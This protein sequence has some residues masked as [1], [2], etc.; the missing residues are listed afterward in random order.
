MQTRIG[1]K[2]VSDIQLAGDEL[3]KDIS[4]RLPAPQF[5]RS[6]LFVFS[7]LCLS[8]TALA[9]APVISGVGNV[10]NY[11]ENAAAVTIDSS[12]TITDSDSA[13][14]NQATVSL[15]TNFSSSEDALV[16]STVNGI[17]G[18]YDSGTGV[19]TLSGTAT[20]AN[21]EGALET[22]KYQNSSDDPSTATRTLSFVVRDTDNNESAADTTTLT[23]TA[24]NDA[25]VVSGVNNVAAFIEGL[26]PVVIDSTITITDTDN[27]NMSTGTV[28]ISG[29]N[30]SADSLVYSTLHGITGSFTNYG[31]HS[32][33]SLSGT[34]TKAQYEEA[35]E[36][37]QFSNSS[38][39]PSTATRTILFAV[40]D[41]FTSSNNPT[42]TLTVTDSAP[43]SISD[44]GNVASYTENGSAV[45][46]DS[47]VTIADT[48]SANLN[49][50]AVSLTTN[51]ASSEDSLVYSTVNGITGSYNSGTGV[52]TLS[53]TAT[54]AEYE[55]ALES[56]QYQ[57]TS[58]NPSTSTRTLSFVVRDTTNLNSTAD[59]T[60]LTVTAVND[61]PVISDVDN[62]P[63]FTENDAATVIDSTITITDADNG[64]MNQAT[65]S[66]TAN[67]SSS[68]DSLVY[69]TVNGITG[70]YN[71]GTGVL[72]LSGAT[73]KANYEGALETV[74]YQNSS[75][76]PSTSTRTISFVVRDSNNGSSSADT[77]TVTVAAVADAPVISGVNNVVSYT[78]NDVAT[79]IDSTIT[80]SDADH[81]NLNQA[82][83]SIT[84]N[85]SSSQDSLVYSTI[86]GIAGS[87]SSGTG[88]LTLSGAATKADYEG[89]LETVK[90]ENSSESPSTATRTLSFVVRDTGNTSSAA[91]TTTLDVAA[92]NDAPVLSNVDNVATFVGGAGAV[93]IDSSIAI[94]DVDSA[95]MSQAT[96]VIMPTNYSTSDSLVYSTIN[97]ITGS[98]EGFSDHGELTL[99]GAATKAQYEEA[100]ES[101]QFQSSATPSIGTRT[102][103]FAVVD[104][105]SLESSNPTTTLIVKSPPIISD[106]ANVANYTENGS[107]VT[108]DSAI[109]I[110]DPDSANLN[111]ATVSITT[112]F[113]SSQDSLV[114]STVNGITGS[115]NSGTGVLTLSAVATKAQYE[116]ALESVQYENSSEDPSTATRTISF[117]ARDADNYSGAPDTT[118]L[119]I[120]AVNDLPT[121]SGVDNVVGYTEND[122]ATIIDSSI[123]IADVDHSNMNQATVS[124]TTNFESPEDS[125]VYST[126]H[127]I[128]GS[129]NGS[130]GV[131]TLSGTATKAQYE[132]ALESVKYSNSSDDPDTNTRTISF[133]VRDSGNGSSSA[134]TTTLTVAAVNDAPVISGVDTTGGWSEFT[135][136]SLVI[137][138]SIS[139][140]D[141]DNGNIN[142]A[143]VS[144]VTNFAS[145]EDSLD[146][147]ATLHGI[148]GSYNSSTGVLTLSG[149]ASKNDYEDALESITYDNLATN[150]NPWHRTISFVVRDNSNAYSLPDNRILDIVTRDFSPTITDVNN[151]ASYTENSS[152]VVI[153]STVTIADTDS[154]HLKEATVSLT[155]NFSSTEDV[156]VYSTVNGIIGAYDSSAGV[157]MLSGRAT[158]AEYEQA[159]ESVQ[160]QNTSDN[161][162]TST[163][164]L[165]YVVWDDTYADSTADTTTLT[166]TAGNDAPVLS[167]VDSMVIYKPSDPAT[168]I[169]PTVKIEDADSTNMNQA[170]VTITNVVTSEDSL[171]YSAVSGI[172]GAYVS[173]T[174][175]LTLSGTATMAQYEEAL[176]SVK[177]ENSSATPTMGARNLSFVVRDT[178]NTSSAADTVDV[179]ITAAPVITDVDNVASYTENGSAVTID[180]SVTISD[181]DNANLNQATVSITTNFSVAQ[182]VLV[183]STV[184]GITGVYNSVAGVLTL[185]GVATKA[186]YE[187]ALE[188]VQ[189]QNS[190]NNPSTATRTLSFVVRDTNYATSA[191]DTTTLTVSAAT[192]APVISGVD[193]VA[194]F[195]A[196]QATEVIIDG[197][198]AISD[199][200][201][202]QLNQATVT[203]TANLAS[204]EDELVYDTI[205]GI[206]GSYNS[207]TGM[208]TLSGNATLA[209]YE[210]ALETVKYWNSSSTPSTS[211]RTISFVV[212][213][214]S[215]TSSAADTTTVT[216][217]ALIMPDEFQHDL[218]D[219]SFL[220]DMGNGDF[221]ALTEGS[222]DVSDGAALYS[223]PI[224]LPPAVNDLKPGLALSYYSGGGNGL[225]GLGW[226]LS[227]LSTI[228]RC[229]AVYA[230]EGDE[231]QDSNPR[232]TNEDRLC[233]DGQKLQ[234]ASDTVPSSA[235]NTTYWAE[236]AEYRTEIDSFSQIRAVGT[237]NGAHQYFEVR[238]KSGL[239]MTYG[240]EEDSQNSRIHAAGQGSGGPVNIWAL[241]K[242]EDRYGNEYT[243]HYQNN[244]S[245]G[246][247]YPTHMVFEPDASVV[248]TYE[249]RDSDISGYRSD[250]PFGY[251]KGHLYKH[252]KI[253]DKIT[254]YVDVSSPG[255]PTSG[256]RVREYD[257]T[258]MRSATTERYLV[259]QIEECG[260]DSGT[261]VCAKPLEFDWQAGELGFASS[262][263]E[264]QTCASE[265]I[266]LSDQAVVDLD[267]DG[268]MDIVATTP[269]ESTTIYWGTGN[270]NNC[271]E[272]T[273]SWTITG[274]N[275]TWTSG[276][277]IATPRGYGWIVIDNAP[278]Q[279]GI[280][281][282]DRANATLEYQYLAPIGDHVVL[283]ADLNNDGLDDF[284]NEYNLWLQDGTDPADFTQVSATA[285][286]GKLQT[287]RESVFVDYTSDGLVDYLALFEA[288]EN[289]DNQFSFDFV[290]P[291][292]DSTDFPY[293][294]NAPTHS[295]I[296]VMPTSQFRNVQDLNG[297]GL[298]D[299]IWHRIPSGSTGY[300]YAKLNTGDGFTAPIDDGVSSG[301]HTNQY[302]YTYDWDKD[303]RQDLIVPNASYDGW[304][305]LVSTYNGGGFEFKDI[306]PSPLPGGV[307]GLASLEFSMPE[308]NMLR[309]D[310]NNDGLVDVAYSPG[311]PGDTTNVWYAKQQQPDLL[312][313]V[314]NGFGAEVKFEYS[315]LVGDANNG[316]PLYTPSGAVVFPQRHAL[317][318]M[319]VVKKL[320][321][322]DGLGDYR[323]RYFN[324]TGAKEDVQGRGFLGFETIVITDP[325]L[326]TVTTVNYEQDFPFTGRVTSSEVKDGNGDLISI[327]DNHYVIHSSN[328][329]FPLMDY[330]IAR[331]Y[332]LTTD[333]AS[334]PLSVTKTENTFDQYGTLT[335]QTTQMGSGLSGTTVTGLKRV[336]VVDNTT[337]THNTTDWL[338]GFI[339]ESILSVSVDGSTGLR[340]S[341][342]EFDPESGT[343]DVAVR[344]DF[345]GT[346][347]WKTTTVTRNANGVIT[348]IEG[349][350]GDLGSTTTD[351]RTMT[352]GVT[353]LMFRTTKTNGLDQET[354]FTY[355]ERFGVVDSEEDPNGLTTTKEYDLLGRLTATTG[356]DDT[357]T[358]IIRYECG[359]APVSCPSAA[360]YLE[361]TEVTNPN[362]S[363]KLGLP[364]NIV[365]YDELGRTVRKQ[366][367]SLNG[368]VAK[369]DTEYYADGRMKRV[370]EP[371]TGSSAVDW[372]TT[373]SYDALSRP[374][375]VTRADGGSVEQNYTQQG[376]LAKM[377]Q[378]VHVLNPSSTQ[379]NTRYTDAL[380]QV[381][382][383]IDAN[384][385]PA[386]Y[387]YDS[388]GNLTE[389]TVN[390]NAATAITITYD[391]ANNK[392]S[393]TDP[394]AGNIDFE[395]NGFGELRKQIWD[396]AVDKSMEFT[397]DVLGR[398]TDRVDDPDTGTS[399]DE[400]SYSW[401][402]DTVKDG[403]L[404]SQSGNGITET[405]DYD[406][407]SRV[408][409]LTT[410]ISGLTGDRVFEYT[411]DAFSRPDTTTYPDGLVVEQ[412][413]HAAGIKV[414]TRDITNPSTPKLLWTIGKDSDARGT[415]FQQRFGNGVITLTTLDEASGRIAA[416]KTGWPTVNGLTGMVGNIQ[417]LT[418]DF[419][420]L[421]NLYTRTTA[422]TDL[423]GDP[424]ED[425]IEIFTYD[426]L[427][428][429]KTSDTTWASPSSPDDR[430][431]TYNYDAL[432]NLTSRTGIGSLTYGDSVR[433]HAVTSANGVSYEYDDYGN[434]IE[435]DSETLEYDVFNKP[436][437]VGDV[438]FSYGPY[439]DRF[440]Q[441]EGAGDRIV[442]YINGGLYEEIVE[443]ATTTQ[444]SHVD[445]YLIR[446]TVSSTTTLTYLHKDYLGSVEAM[447]DASGNMVSVNR[448]SFDPWGLR[449]EADWNDGDPTGG[450][451]D[452]YPTTRGFT[453]HEMVDQVGLIHMNGRVYDPVIGRF[454]SA[455]LLV[456]HP[457][458]TQSFNRYSYVLNNPL[459]YTDPSGYADYGG[460]EGMTITFTQ[461][462]FFASETTIRWQEPDSG[463]THTRTETHVEFSMTTVTFHI[464][465]APAAD[466][467]A[468]MFC[469]T[470][471]F[472]VG[473]IGASMGGAPSMAQV[474]PPNIPSIQG[475][476]SQSDGWK[477]GQKMTRKQAADRYG[478]FDDGKW[479]NEK[480]W[481]EDYWLKDEIVK[482]PHYNW[483]NPITKKPL[484]KVQMNKDIIPMFEK[485]LSTLKANGHLGDLKTYDGAFWARNV[486][487]SEKPSCHSIG[488]CLDMNALTNTKN[489]GDL[490]QA[491]INAFT[492]AGFYH[493]SAFDDPMHWGLGF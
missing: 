166:L 480:E 460:T 252:P 324:Y 395:Y 35:L 67:F 137:D 211:P 149:V 52:L 325:S 440:K 435:R 319:Q 462:S 367:H 345:V 214:T 389:T 121:L 225:V 473:G 85:F 336:V 309:G 369:V 297:D 210:Q 80:I 340:S 200:D 38:S 61:L 205:N 378:T 72:T 4:L 427:N 284:I 7:L 86:N 317:R 351:A 338:L 189:Y 246:D 48:D 44:V 307:S 128:T 383:V 267:N 155:T 352:L 21:Y 458:D 445:G 285:F 195:S 300:W 397:Y 422:R 411:Y 141:P 218:N 142:Q 417:D 263:G 201:S 187:Q 162:S 81:S 104:S 301:T 243:I 272:E 11:T 160:Y 22:V 434:V 423:A 188:S 486:A 404:T 487:G 110:T 27:A 58:D 235:S 323:H 42:T 331:E 385:T 54:K 384:G 60:T 161:P 9:A 281:E 23:V 270:A 126:M 181:G 382:R 245:D 483:I 100:L 140:T 342:T 302:S 13:N 374:L 333:S 406:S 179:V 59:T 94:A 421:G 313:K 372:N 31:T 420:T 170:T 233:L 493:G 399:S 415:L 469:G 376:G 173:G 278:D 479:A 358:R 64:D 53:G 377:V 163:R 375:E 194:T 439:H 39:T 41:P 30:S 34:A 416:I 286:T 145:A 254:T 213:D 315:P 282:V 410:S 174:G 87:Y 71:S 197:S 408:E 379:V 310:F 17:T 148:T 111:Q 227:G 365:Y 330:G 136:S 346:P 357:V 320:S 274:T 430:G 134:D 298:Q 350:A 359:S 242:V 124:I 354:T 463:L 316:E 113:S 36:S 229:P 135:G 321:V 355:D 491:V 275:A 90:Y 139:I 40:N 446:S 133:V 144:I 138:S 304:R 47:S 114:Y 127:G 481:I 132:E 152:A 241:D 14:L 326:D 407:L 209:Q 449:Q 236:D 266:D 199:T 108:I 393:I 116:Q 492:G 164:T 49:Q 191:A 305:V 219:N 37:V 217:H 327:T 450:D 392:T 457:L 178:T 112:N 103:L 294:S 400:T 220:P 290:V 167:E 146:Y 361:A 88:V 335:D 437:R 82:T 91:D 182:D 262:S 158:L 442:Y 443:G 363:D 74:K 1:L 249:D 339:E 20:K 280:V 183:Y 490:S 476:S 115:Y 129:Y 364:L 230:S 226:S 222:A 289:V 409:S 292:S 276:R 474:P 428:R 488:I 287:G 353:G 455:D 349:E 312:Q 366:I 70:S 62:V 433:V 447:T 153:D 109:T 83:V 24:V 92:V 130:T 273:S 288:Y 337:I 66:I 465:F 482:D 334:Y 120:S 396:G 77:T 69:T 75:D 101:V 283:V 303:G 150:P 50:A 57:N 26:G 453:G 8:D 169:D 485:A 232:Y 381:T 438:E 33:L 196:G 441:D 405:Y 258:Y 268:Y 118:T 265:D 387:E 12:V 131:L 264:L 253:L 452:Y 224:V 426:D 239:I 489:S 356:A 190:S 419:D 348:G 202:N 10:A 238:T 19:L 107:A 98:Y 198:V 470:E 212:R 157:L 119:T 343:L 388:E 96:L 105:A 6:L 329:R 464:S 414:Q 89:A 467:A 261:R 322:S 76:D 123:T 402:W 240:R 185:S 186:E 259:D 25:P 215:N 484:R 237:L 5:V 371:F 168:I 299:L 184:N 231:A 193:T 448:M 291:H 432:G 454:L 436:T 279:I 180:S 370:S 341:E 373:E 247:Y 360:V 16:Y 122:A 461:I 93:V 63:G 250:I 444:R 18:S 99:S 68:E 431:R 318:S 391:V 413:Y 65:V 203:I 102:I 208:L 251:D 380:N 2:G 234:I 456:T 165:S 418:Y 207:G 296:G 425:I 223:V 176:E 255:S 206:T 478:A 475:S 177:Y 56:V 228:S 32:V 269:G 51:F 84:S 97:G 95:N 73:T 106:V 362:A 328:A 424:L 394:D 293:Y 46:I 28:V 398:K 466:V 147:P 78:E 257:I 204:S 295:Q 216:L 306:S 43:P 159:L 171:V 472:G 311:S 277:L 175:V 125:L 117:V 248:F 29:N 271:F 308:A 451:P 344:R 15:T 468:S 314:T 347:V 151:V 412:Q 368:E 55:Q 256:T 172:T 221:V 154:T 244:N 260:F 3:L 156:L 429:L 477:P 459:R 79:V 403:L 332:G 386:D 192:D 390:S 471:F 143:T 401:T 45:T